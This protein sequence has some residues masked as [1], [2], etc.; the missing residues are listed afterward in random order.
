[1]DFLQ[2]VCQTDQVW[3]VKGPLDYTF[4]IVLIELLK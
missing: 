4:C 3:T 2:N 1:M